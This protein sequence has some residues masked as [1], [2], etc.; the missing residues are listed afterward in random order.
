[1][2]HDDKEYKYVYGI[3]ILR[4]HPSP[5]TL[6]SVIDGS[7]NE[8]EYNKIKKHLDNCSSCSKYVSMFKSDK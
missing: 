1:M 5:T 8:H 6:N 4:K 7:I 2:D 3:R